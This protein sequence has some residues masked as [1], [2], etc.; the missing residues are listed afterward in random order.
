MTG[1]QNAV[2]WMGLMLILI[3]LFTTGQWSAIWTGTILAGSKAVATPKDKNGKDVKPGYKLDNNGNQVP[4]GPN[5]QV[6]PPS[7]FPPVTQESF[8][9]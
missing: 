5:E 9:A 6:V 2:M 4:L 1:K 7:E 8:P 3:R